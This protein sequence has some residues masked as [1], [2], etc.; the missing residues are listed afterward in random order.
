LLPIGPTWKQLETKK[1][2][3]DRLENERWKH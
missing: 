2:E 1:R 3:K